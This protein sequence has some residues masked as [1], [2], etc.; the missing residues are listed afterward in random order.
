MCILVAVV[1]CIILAG[2]LFW[3]FVHS[4]EKKQT[5]VQLLSPYLDLC[6]W[7]LILNGYHASDNE[8]G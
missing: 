7:I 1:A 3:G 5:R 6:L 2:F 4:R 8:R